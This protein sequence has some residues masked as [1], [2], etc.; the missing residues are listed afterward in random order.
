MYSW[1]KKSFQI[2]IGLHQGS[3][4]SLFLFPMFI[5]CLTEEVQEA[6]W[7]KLF[8]DGVLLSGEISDEVEERLQKW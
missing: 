2:E 6:P 4:L 3:A 7:D 8:A 1:D 5:I